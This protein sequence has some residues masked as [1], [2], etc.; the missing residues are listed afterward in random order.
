MLAI[1]NA[2]L[3]RRL[4]ADLSMVISNRPEARGL[5]AA[6]GLGIRTAVLDHTE[7]TTRESFDTALDQLLREQSPDWI[8]L[9]GFMRILGAD[10][11]KNWQGRIINIHPSLL[12][13]HPGLDTHARALAAGDKEAGA[14]VHFVTA[15]LDAGPVIDQ[16]RVPVLP[17]DTPELLAQRVLAEE[18]KLLIRAL[19][20]C[21]TNPVQ[22]TATH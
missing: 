16:V 22:R 13:A 9:A 21:L 17:G 1:A 19:K 2:C 7:F 10:F 20:Q 6:Q 3:D 14:S 15:D 8:V 5:A 18:H 12:P 4:D 11:V